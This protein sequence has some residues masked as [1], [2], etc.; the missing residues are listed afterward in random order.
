[1]SSKQS[2][3]LA[4]SFCED[5]KIDLGI[6][7]AIFPFMA[8][9]PIELATSQ[10]I[11]DLFTKDS[12]YSPDEWFEKERF[13][14]NH[15]MRIFGGMC[16]IRSALYHVEEENYSAV[17]NTIRN[18]FY[19]DDSYKSLTSK[20]LEIILAFSLGFIIGWLRLLILKLLIWNGY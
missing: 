4:F 1:M 12:I 16:R 5:T 20:D 13:A 10:L 9:A 11:R 17:S 8:E 18:L 19:N 3:R 2:K 15:S 7:N 6:T 14:L